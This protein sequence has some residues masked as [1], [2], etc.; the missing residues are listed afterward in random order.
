MAWG[1]VA[2]AAAQGPS[3]TRADPVQVTRSTTPV[4]DRFRPYTFTT[5]GRVVAPAGYCAPG[6][7]PVGSSCVP[8]LCPPGVTNIAYC[9]VPG[10]AVICSGVPG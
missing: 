1:G 2:P 5:T 10:L 8:I 6:Q 7:S 9:F 3:F 4:R